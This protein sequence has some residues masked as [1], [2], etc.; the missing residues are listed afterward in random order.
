MTSWAS[1]GFQEA[2]WGLS[3]WGESRRQVGGSDGGAGWEMN[4]EEK[5]IVGKHEAPWKGELEGLLRAP[6]MGRG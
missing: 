1:E 5:V 6:G 3:A 2:V 4:Q